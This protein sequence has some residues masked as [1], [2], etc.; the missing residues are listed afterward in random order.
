H[1]RSARYLLQR[2]CHAN[3]S[4][5]S[6]IVEVIRVAKALMRRQ[7]EILASEGVAFARCEIGERHLERPADFGVHMMDL[8]RKS[9]RR[10]PFHHGVRVEE[11]SVNPVWCRTKH[12]MESDGIRSHVFSFTYSRCPPKESRNVLYREKKK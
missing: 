7:F 8:A 9:I 1:F 2:H 4:R 3:F 6:R 12:G 5:Q 10:Q 11:R